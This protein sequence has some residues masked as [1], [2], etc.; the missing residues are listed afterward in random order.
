[1]K[2]IYEKPQTECF[3]VEVSSHLLNASGHYKPYVRFG[4]AEE[5]GYNWYKGTKFFGNDSWIN[6]GYAPGN[7]ATPGGDGVLSITD[8]DGNLNSRVKGGLWADD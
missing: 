8:D 5:D 4:L 1:M 6:E 2:K 7:P 3:S